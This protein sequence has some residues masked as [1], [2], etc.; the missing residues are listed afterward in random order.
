MLRNRSSAILGEIVLVF[1]QAILLQA[2]FVSTNSFAQSAPPFPSVPPQVSN[3]KDPH[4][5]DVVVEDLTSPTF[6]QTHLIPARPLIGFVDEKSGYSVS[7]IRLQLSL[8]HIF[9]LRAY[10]S[11]RPPPIF[12]RK[13]RSLRSAA[14]IQSSATAPRRRVHPRPTDL[15]DS[16]MPPTPRAPAPSTRLAWL[17]AWVPRSKAVSL[18]PRQT[19]S[20][21]TSAALIRSPTLPFRCIT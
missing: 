15:T 16:A 7:L 20:P 10:S 13:M 4:L 21:S 8:I 6:E 18:L 5:S 2:I 1:L 9:R 12:V 11:T 17:T 14:S 3:L 19:R